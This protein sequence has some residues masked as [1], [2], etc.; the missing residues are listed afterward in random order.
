M[1]NLEVKGLSGF[2]FLCTKLIYYL[3][4]QYITE[5]EGTV[6]A[7]RNTERLNLFSLDPDIAVSKN[8][9]FSPKF[10]EAVKYRWAGL[11]GVSKQLGIPRRQLSGARGAASGSWRYPQGMPSLITGRL[12][13]QVAPAGHLVQSSKV[14]GP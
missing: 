13:V 7:S 10:L 8:L 4:P 14:W 1:V 11:T 9:F 5:T 3:S 6:K 2:L 12:Q